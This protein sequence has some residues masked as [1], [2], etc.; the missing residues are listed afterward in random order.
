MTEYIEIIHIVQGISPYVH[1][2][3]YAV[4]T[5]CAFSLPNFF[6]W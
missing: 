6:A 3:V 2:R 4:Y 1:T 5:L